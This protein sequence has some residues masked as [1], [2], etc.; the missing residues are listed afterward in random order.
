MANGAGADVYPSDSL[1][2]MTVLVP[3]SYTARG[4]QGGVPFVGSMVYAVCMRAGS[5]SGVACSVRWRSGKADL[6][7]RG[8]PSSAT[9]RRGMSQVTTTIEVWATERSRHGITRPDCIIK[10]VV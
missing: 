6:R 8:L 2:L 9:G 4:T 10:V 3:S 5:M 1:N 7:G